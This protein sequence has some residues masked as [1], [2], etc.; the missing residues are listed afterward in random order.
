MQGVHRRPEEA[1]RPYLEADGHIDPAAERGAHG[2]RGQAQVSEQLGE[3]LCE[4]D[5]GP[6][7]SHHHTRSDAGEVDS[8]GL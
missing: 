5:S 2:A 4:R 8:P 1:P 3:G 6:L 7:L